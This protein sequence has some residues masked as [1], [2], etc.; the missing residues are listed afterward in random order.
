MDGIEAAK[1]IRSRYSISIIFVTSHNDKKT[2]ERAKI[3]E[4]NGYFIKPVEFKDFKLAIDN[5]RLP[6]SSINNV[7][8]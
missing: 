3:V 6:K 4:L 8:E 7:D 5:I 1:E 2:K